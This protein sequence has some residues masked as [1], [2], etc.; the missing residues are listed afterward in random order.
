MIKKAGTRLALLA[1]CVFF[2]TACKV[3]GDVVSEGS[4]EPPSEIA[5]EDGLSLEDGVSSEDGSSPEN[6]L[7]P[8][9]GSS[10]EDVD[11][12]PT[13][14]LTAPALRPWDADTL[15]AIRPRDNVA[16]YVR[17]DGLYAAD[18]LTGE[19]ICLDASPLVAA[20]IR[21]LYLYSSLHL[22]ADHTLAA[23]TK[24]TSLFLVPVDFDGPPFEPQLLC[25]EIEVE[26][27][28]YVF[29]S[30]A[31]LY[32]PAGGGLYAYDLSSGRSDLLLDSSCVY[33]YLVAAPDKLYAERRGG[34]A[35]GTVEI[36]LSDRSVSMVVL[37]VLDSESGLLHPPVGVSAD[38]RYLYLIRRTSSGSISTDG[39][40]VAVYDSRSQT[41]TSLDF[42]TLQRSENFSI[43][44][45]DGT[46]AFMSGFNREMTLGNKTLCLWDPATGKTTNVSGEDSGGAMNPYFSHDGQTLLYSA[47]KS[48]ADYDLTAAM[49]AVESDGEY[50]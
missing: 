35:G 11:P 39:I 29:A 49:A 45:T 10:P 1:L 40:S 9:D 7:S 2:L 14:D 15:T 50:Y 25:D 42:T 23:Y 31:L 24:G 5:L 36:D 26:R 37:D 12:T 47:G 43:H 17:D 41:Y 4:P 30:D 46:L 6:E 28:G 44:P 20:G 32:A 38:G 22:T 21:D 8:E 16:L 19:E 27:G 13:A 3:P 48:F 33:T 34:D 18:L